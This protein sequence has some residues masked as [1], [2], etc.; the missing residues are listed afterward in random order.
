VARQSKDD[1]RGPLLGALL[2]RAHQ[3]VTDEIDRAMSE[4]GF[5]RLQHSHNVVLRTLWSQ[6][7]GVRST[8]LATRARI[9]KQSMGAMVDS[10][11]VLGHVERI[12]DPHDGRAKLIRLTALGR[13]AGRI[14]RGTVKR[15]E[16]DWAKRVGAERLAAMRSTLVDL[17]L[18]LDYDA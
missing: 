13:E 17:L 14:I 1:D 6:P 15:V 7:D 3:A 2:R 11:E 10:L 9:T 18:S 16:A 12:D 5:E 4:A 8:E